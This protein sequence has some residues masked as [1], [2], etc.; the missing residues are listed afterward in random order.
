MSLCAAAVMPRSEYGAVVRRTTYRISGARIWTLGQCDGRDGEGIA[1]ARA[2]GLW[3]GLRP[4]RVTA[5]DLSCVL[6]RC[7][8]WRSLV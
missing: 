6:V 8:K 4:D 5:V 2:D 7:L 1:L 3:L